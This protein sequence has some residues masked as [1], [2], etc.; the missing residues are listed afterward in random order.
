MKWYEHG[1]V[2]RRDWVIENLEFLGLESR[3]LMLVLVI[4]Y[5]NSLH[6]N[7]TM[8][9][10]MKKTGFHTNEL[11]TVISLLCA[12]QYLDIRPTKQGVLFLLDGLFSTNVQKVQNH[13][14]ANLMDLFET[15]FARPLSQGEMQKIA[16][17]NLMYEKK[18]IIQALRRASANGKLNMTMIERILMKEA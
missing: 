14:D 9:L 8:D 16:D 1:Y 3:E 11:D 13:L 18:A 2:N 6:E 10:L 17:W 5:Y 12:K 7:I 15:E 4:D